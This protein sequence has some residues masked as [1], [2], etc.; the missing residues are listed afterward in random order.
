MTKRYA[1][2]RLAVLLQRRLSA[3]APYRSQKELAAEAGLQNPNLLSM[4][5]TGEERVPL[6][7]VPGLAKA[8]GIEPHL[9][10]RLAIEQHEDDEGTKVLLSIFRA[11]VSENE[12]AFLEA[13]RTASGDTDPP[14]PRTFGKIMSALFGGTRPS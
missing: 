7:R 12:L 1:H 4:Y 11:P 14:V 8:L 10:A 5:K 3:L 2:T 13:I 9:M 6:G